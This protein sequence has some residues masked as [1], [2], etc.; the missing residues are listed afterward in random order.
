MPAD[1]GVTIKAPKTPVILVESSAS[2]TGAAKYEDVELNLE[3]ITVAEK[4]A[5]RTRS[6]EATSRL[7]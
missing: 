6:P 7:F 5:V 1:S 4:S 2:E 3:A